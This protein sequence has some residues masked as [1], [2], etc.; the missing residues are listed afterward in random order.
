MIVILDGDSGAGKTALCKFLVES[1]WFY[2]GKYTSRP[3]RIEELNSK[4]AVGGKHVSESFFEKKN[5]LD[6]FV[7]YKYGKYRY[8]IEL[9]EFEKIIQSGES[10]CVV[11]RDT[12]TIKSIV[13]KFASFCK[14]SVISVYTNEEV[15]RSRLI[16]AGYTEDMANERVFR[17]PKSIERYMKNPNLYDGVVINDM[18]FELSKKCLLGIISD[19]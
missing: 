10:I 12:Q 5:I 1:G 4:S 3:K 16:D 19:D 17:K 14:V 15:C 13:Q 2:Y 9:S 8:G 6:G 11:I 7:S 18:S